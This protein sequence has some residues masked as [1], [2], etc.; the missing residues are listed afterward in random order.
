MGVVDHVAAAELLDHREHRAHAVGHLGGHLAVAAPGGVADHALVG[1]HQRQPAVDD[2]LRVQGLAEVPDLRDAQLEG[3]GGGDKARL[4]DHVQGQGVEDIQAEVAPDAH[5]EI[6]GQPR[7]AEVAH[8]GLVDAVIKEPAQHR[9]DILGLAVGDDPGQHRDGRD[10]VCHKGLQQ[11]EVLVHHRQGHIDVFGLQRRQLRGQLL[12]GEHLKDHGRLRALG[13]ALGPCGDGAHPASGGCGPLLTELGH[14]TAPQLVDGRG[15][16]VQAR[17]GLGPVFHTGVGRAAGLEHLLREV[18]RG[19]ALAPGLLGHGAGDHGLVAVVVKGDGLDGLALFRHGV[20]V[21]RHPSQLP[22]RVALPGQGEHL[23]RVLVGLAPHAEHV[24]QIPVEVALGEALA[25]EGPLQRLHLLGG[26]LAVLLE[27]VG[28]DSG[29]DGGVLRAL[30]AAL[31]L[32]AGDPRL[33]QLLE[34]VHQTVVLEG[35]GVVVHAAAQGILQTAGLGAHAP[36]A[37]ALADERGHIA[38]ARMAEAQR[39]VDEDLRLDGRV[40]GDEADLFDA[41]LPGQHRPRHAQLRRGLHPLQVVD[42]HLGAGVQGDVRQVLADGGGQAQVLHQDGVGPGFG[43]EPRALQ[44]ALHLPVVDQGIQSHID[45]AAADAAVA[46]GPCEFFV[47][48]ILCAAPGVEVAHA[49]IHGVR[50]VLDGGDDSLGRAGG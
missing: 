46:H 23:L 31:D 25:G 13:S 15:G 7:V 49:E 32:H 48:E 40:F 30:H 28:V 3:G 41:Q 17:I 19:Q 21:H 39:P 14:Q 11:G 16:Q 18:G 37:A 36:V 42:G 27:G 22:L 33:L 38:L 50:P 9:A 2:H 6:P 45:L 34:P 5:A 44:R 35:E 4:P 43:G 12:G 8:Q 47:V 26:G 10:A 20:E 29:D 1:D 24:L